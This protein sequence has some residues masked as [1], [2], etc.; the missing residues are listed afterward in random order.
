[1]KTGMEF[2][3][4]LLGS[5]FIFLSMQGFAQTDSLISINKTSSNLK[6]SSNSSLIYPGIRLGIEIPV[7]SVTLSRII[8][9]KSIKAIS[10]DRF[11]SVLSGWYHHQDFHDN[12]YLTAE[13]TMRS[14]CKGGFFTD[15]NIGTGYSRTFLGGTTYK[16]DNNGTV[17]IIKS[18][19]YN[20]ALIIAGG[21]LG[22]DLSK[23]ERIPFS[24]FSKFDIL[25]MFP[26]N[27]TVYFRPAIELGLIYKPANFIQVPVKKWI[28]K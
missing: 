5:L 3:R 16:V 4:T 28:R 19:G 7:Y 15:F 22:F 1:M 2:R 12:L 20:Y 10:K 21:S 6:I 18:A 8:L 17:S 24:V 11:V 9:K 23:K 13:W 14:T 27:S 26:Y 25:T